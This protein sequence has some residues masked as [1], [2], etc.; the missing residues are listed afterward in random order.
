[1]RFCYLQNENYEVSLYQAHR[2][3]VQKHQPPRKRLLTISFGEGIVPQFL[4]SV[5]CETS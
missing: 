3:R 1:M 5:K 2:K 4:W